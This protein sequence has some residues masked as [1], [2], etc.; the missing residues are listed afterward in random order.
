VSLFMR[1][2]ELSG[3]AIS[4]QQQIAEA[5]GRRQPCDAILTHPRRARVLHSREPRGC[6]PS[7]DA[8][9]AIA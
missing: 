1:G 2:S 8:A 3:R 5:E 9:R 7:V 4:L 6:R